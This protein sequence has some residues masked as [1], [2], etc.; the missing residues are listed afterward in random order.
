[1]T[2]ATDPAIVDL[3]AQVRKLRRGTIY[4]R[5]LSFPAGRKVFLSVMTKAIG[6]S[7][8]VGEVCQPLKV[9]LDTPP[10]GLPIDAHVGQT[11]SVSGTTG[12]LRV[13]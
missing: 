13:Q 9:W 10:Y 2:T 6:R 12:I 8:K 4:P 5:D 7:Y 1:M 3:Y 11:A